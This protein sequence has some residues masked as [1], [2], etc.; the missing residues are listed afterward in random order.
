LHETSG[1]AEI[2]VE[3]YGPS[4]PKEVQSRMFDPFFT[5]KAEGTGLGLSVSRR[6]VEAHGG[7]IQFTTKPS[8]TTFTVF[9]PKGH[10]LDRSLSPEV[11]K[12]REVRP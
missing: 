10:N 7:T 6:I 12:R 11:E 9:L 1:G 5:T 4:I 3:D 8:G 2:E